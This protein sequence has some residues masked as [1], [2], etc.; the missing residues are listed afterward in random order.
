MMLWK[1]VDFH[2]EKLGIKKFIPTPTSIIASANPANKDS[3]INNEKIDLNEFPFLAPLKDRFD[4][5]FIFQ[6]KKDPKERDQF[7]DELAEVE[8]KRE[9]NEL[10][11]YTEFLIK[12]IQY[13]K[14]FDPV[15]TDEAW[16]MT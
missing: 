8:V 16:Y 5:I 15:L 7:N 10:P 3:W 1:N 4:L 6:Q 13:A 12:Y 11:D 2:F 14:Q 9:R